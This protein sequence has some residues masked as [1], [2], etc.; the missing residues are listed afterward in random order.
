MLGKNF[1]N[2]QGDDM[3]FVGEEVAGKKADQSPSPVRVA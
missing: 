1:M 3:R 2:G